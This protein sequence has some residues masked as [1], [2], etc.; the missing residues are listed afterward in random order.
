MGMRKAETKEVIRKNIESVT[1]ARICDCCKKEII[2]VEKRSY[3]DRY[4][5]FVLT[6]SHSDW[7]NDSCESIMEYDAC[8]VECAL[9][10]AGEYL[11]DAQGFSNTGEIQIKHAN[12]LEA[13]TDRTYERNI[14]Y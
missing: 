6:T 9:K 7:G 12:T 5:Y 2:P 14:E 11:D 4:S 1:I 10:L 8:S 13:G 3:G